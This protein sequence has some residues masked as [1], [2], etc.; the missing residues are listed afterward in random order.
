MITEDYVSFE[1]A[2]LLEKKGFLKGVDLRLTQNLSFYDDIGLHHNLNKWYDS[3]IQDKIDFVVAPTYKMALKWLREMHNIF[4]EP[5][6]GETNGK[7]WYDFDIIPV[8]GR[9][10][11]WNLYNNPPFVKR[12]S[13]KEAVEAALKYCLENLI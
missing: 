3:L 6:A 10:I 13:Y 2:K 5:R 8:N 9:K 12:N 4:I 7:T 1:I 11:A